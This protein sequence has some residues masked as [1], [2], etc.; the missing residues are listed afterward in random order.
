LKASNTKNLVLWA[1]GN[2]DVEGN[3]SWANLA[4]LKRAG[5]ALLARLGNDTKADISIGIGRYHPGLRGLAYSYQDARA[6]LTLGQRI[7]GRNQVHCLD[8]LGIAGF[9]GVSDE[10]TKVELATHL[11]SPLDHEPELLHTLSTFFAANCSPSA[12]AGELAIHRNTL[13]YRLDKIASLTGLDPR[14]FDDAVQIRLALVL[15][16]LHGNA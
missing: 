9:V 6:A 1:E 4:A 10:K 14:R 16:S 15:R 2:G 13:S 11:L 12:T 8:E 3:G 5:N 7:H